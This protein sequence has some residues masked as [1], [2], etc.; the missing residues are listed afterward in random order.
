MRSNDYW[1]SAKTHGWGWGLPA[2]WQGWVTYGVAAS[3]LIAVFFLFPP[4]REPVNFML[5]TG[6]IALVLIT[7]C[8]L[9]GEPPRWGKGR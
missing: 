8:W 9:K 3:L 2:R 6:L 1:F 4:A 7:V 5:G